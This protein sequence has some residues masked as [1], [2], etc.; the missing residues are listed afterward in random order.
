MRKIQRGPILNNVLFMPKKDIPISCSSCWR[1][2]GF[3]CDNLKPP[4]LALLWM[5]LMA[6]VV[7]VLLPSK[8]RAS[9][10][11]KCSRC[12]CK[13]FWLPS[14]C[15]LFRFWILNCEQKQK[16]KKERTRNPHK[17]G[18]GLKPV[19]HEKDTKGYRWCP[20]IKWCFVT[21]YR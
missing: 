17:R 5:L 8:R 21:A 2:F 10:A 19:S 9:A 16:K 4:P 1:V 12:F 14:V 7:I 11:S 3:G 13:S 6:P 20:L 15:V 18:K